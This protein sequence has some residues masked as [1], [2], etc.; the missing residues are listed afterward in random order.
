VPLRDLLGELTG[1]PVYVDGHSRALLHAEVLFGRASRVGSVLHVFV[2]N[3]VD[4]AFATRGEAHYGSRAQA[5]AIAHL[6]VEG[7]REPCACGRIGCLEAAVSE[8]TLTRRA[9]EQGIVDAPD[10]RTLFE[11]ARAGNEP[12]LELFRERSQQVGRAVALLMDVFGPESVVVTDPTLPYLPR[13]LD[14]LR[15]ATR[16][17]VRTVCDIDN[18]LMPTSFPGQVLE[19]AGG[20]VVLDALYRNPLN[21]INSE[22]WNVDTAGRFR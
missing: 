19:T 2:G 21:A 18:M 17:S 7:S 15:V 10:I 8:Q 14:A 12:A 6:P 1:L 20:A 13:A 11:A 5:G 9:Y 16:E 22:A 3:V 4:A